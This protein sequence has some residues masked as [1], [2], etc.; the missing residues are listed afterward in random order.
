MG[1]SGLWV[2]ILAAYTWVQSLVC[3]LLSPTNQQECYHRTMHVARKR[4][5]RPSFPRGSFAPS[6]VYLTLSAQLEWI[7]VGAL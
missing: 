6:I 5:Y 3:P 4:D 2:R 7:K 1:N